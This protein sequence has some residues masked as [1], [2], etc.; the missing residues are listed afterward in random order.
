MV[1]AAETG[2]AD[3][4]GALCGPAADFFLLGRSDLADLVRLLIAVGGDEL[5]RSAVLSALIVSAS[6]A[7]DPHELR[8]WAHEVQRIDA[9]HPT[10]LGGLMRWLTLAWH[11][12]IPASVDV[13]LEA[14]SDERLPL[15]SRDLFVGIAVLDHFSL[16]AAPDPRPGLV[17][18]ALEVAG[19]TT[20]A[21]ARVSCLLGAAWSAV[22]EAP[23]RAVQLVHRALGDMD[24][25]PA[26]TRTTM[27]GSVARL[28]GRLDPQVAAQGLLEQLDAAPS[29]RSFVDLIPVFYGA[30]LLG[31]LGRSPTSPAVAALTSRPAPSMMDVVDLARDVVG[32]GDERSVA[33]LAAGVRSGLATVVTGASPPA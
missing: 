32:L 28:L 19:R 2:S 18:R 17:E 26:L 11:G 8:S 15:A 6:G 29:R 25:L 3:L 4:A 14:A 5:Q 12:D 23:E 10:G 13:C 24:R 21:L 16:T 1:F 30:A 27:P 9:H 20:M 7:T 33:E 22:D 31:R